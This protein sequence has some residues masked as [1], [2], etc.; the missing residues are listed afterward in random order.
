[1]DTV[2][3][4]RN[5]GMTDANAALLAMLQANKDALNGL[6]DLVARDSKSEYRLGVSMA[7]RDAKLTT[8]DKSETLSFF[9][10][11]NDTLGSGGIQN[12]QFS[13]IPKRIRLSFAGANASGGSPN[14]P[15][16]VPVIILSCFKNNLNTTA[17]DVITLHPQIQQNVYYDSVG[18]TWMYVNNYDWSIELPLSY[19]TYTVQFG[20]ISAVGVLTKIVSSIAT[21]TLFGNRYSDL[22]V[23]AFQ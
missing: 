22:S 21:T 19:R 17:D 11:S 20:K 15:T 5:N 3:N 9:A 23:T 1:M 13:I 16:T 6:R 4:P 18:P 8:Y 7:G 2:P 14:G 10:F 12:L